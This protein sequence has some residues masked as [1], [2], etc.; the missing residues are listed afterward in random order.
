MRRKDFTLQDLVEVL[1]LI[2]TQQFDK[3]GRLQEI[4]TERGRKFEHS[5]GL[6]DNLAMLWT[7]NVG[8]VQF[9]RFMRTWD[10]HSGDLRYPVPSPFS[11]QNSF[12]IFN[13]TEDMYDYQYGANR[14][15]LAGHIAAEIRKEFKITL[16][17][18]NNTE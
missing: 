10:R 15:E 18:D 17:K 5:Y 4:Y 7:D 1:E 16:D 14:C 12:D 6:C 8:F 13:S 2:A 11:N 3:G 9:K